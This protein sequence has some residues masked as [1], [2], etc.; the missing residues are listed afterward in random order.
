MKNVTGYLRT[1]NLQDS[2]HIY[3]FLRMERIKYLIAAGEKVEA[4]P[5]RYG[6]TFFSDGLFEIFLMWMGKKPIPLLNRKEYEVQ[7][8]IQQFFG[9][10][11]IRQYKLGNFIYNWFV[12]SHDLLIEF[13]EKEH[14]TSKLMRAND[15]KKAR[16]NL[17]VV[18]EATVMQDLAV[19]AQSFPP[20]KLTPTKPI[21]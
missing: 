21:F 10:E 9:D 6:G 11:V 17:F 13:N 5:G 14:E 1:K 18:R 20:P 4:K 16:D 3:N 7:N 8:F 15:A 2:D 12:P 19:L